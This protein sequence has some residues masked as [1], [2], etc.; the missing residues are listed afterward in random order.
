MWKT[1]VQ[2]SVNITIRRSTGSDTGYTYI[3][4]IKRAYKR[5]TARKC[6]TWNYADYLSF[7]NI[8]VSQEEYARFREGVPYF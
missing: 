6:L 2:I 4:K 5:V 7:H 8:Q 3:F 1:R